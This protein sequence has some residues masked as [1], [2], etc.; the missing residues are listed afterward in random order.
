MKY[1]L[2]IIFSLLLLS[3]ATVEKNQQRTPSN[4]RDSGFVTAFKLNSGLLFSK[5]LPGAYTNG[6]VHPYGKYDRAWCT[7]DTDSSGKISGEVKVEDSLAATAC[8]EIGARLPT[9]FEI[10]GLFRHF[11]HSITSNGPVLTEIGLADFEAT[12]GIDLKKESIWSSTLLFDVDR[13]F[14]RSAW[15]HNHEGRIGVERSSAHIVL[16]VIDP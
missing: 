2:T 5:A 4:T 13:K 6:C 7:Y 16:C 11:N 10:E 15:K 12:F 1:I 14:A 8:S 3:C 9:S